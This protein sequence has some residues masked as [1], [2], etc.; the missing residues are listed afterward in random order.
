MCAPRKEGGLQHKRGEWARAH[1]SITQLQPAC[2]PHNRVHRHGR[3]STEAK[4]RWYCRCLIQVPDSGQVAQL[5]TA[6]LRTSKPSQLRTSKPSSPCCV[7]HCLPPTRNPLH[8]QPMCHRPS[9]QS[10]PQPFSHAL[11]HAHLQ[12]PPVCRRDEVLVRHPVQV[13]SC[14]HQLLKLAQVLLVV[15]L[16]QDGAVPAGQGSTGEWASAHTKRHKTGRT[17]YNRFPRASSYRHACSA[18]QGIH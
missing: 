6:Q 1:K 16:R 8:P 3:L 17:S 12:V 5:R 15:R 7:H 10:P 2:C 11:P 13:H 9:Q 14:L 18:I 4:R